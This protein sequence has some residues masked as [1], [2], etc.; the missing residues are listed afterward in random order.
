MI[1]DQL[2]NTYSFWGLWNP[3]LLFFIILAAIIYLLM[4]GPLITLF[5]DSRYV[6]TSKK[7]LFLLGLLILYLAV[8]SPLH[9]IGHDFLFSAHMLEQA[10]VY[11]AVPPLLL[12]GLPGWLLT[13]LWTNTGSKRVLTILTHPIISLLFF[14]GL[15]S[16]YHMPLLFDRITQSGPLHTM[17][18]SMLFLSA[19]SMWWSVIS[20]ISE[21]E[22][23]SDLKKIGFVFVSG[24]LLYPACALIIFA[25]EPLY[26][27][28][29]NVPQL[30]S[31]LTPL[32]DQQL[33]GIIMKLL[34]E[35]IFI[36]TLAVLFA[37]WY[38]KENRE[39]SNETLLSAP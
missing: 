12:L 20:P 2:K 24:L 23:L 27:T 34:Q 13:P 18:H 31:F 3:N 8:G 21:Q 30:F 1:Y 39:D 4:T 28:Y 14:N 17:T 7:W 10:L 15:F 38:R 9:I 33:G 19:I 6:K 29:R 5:K 26:E 32:Y 22:R 11:M 36:I 37:I 16:F 25:D 35:G